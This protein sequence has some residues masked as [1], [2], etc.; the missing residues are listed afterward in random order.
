MPHRIRE[1]GRFA[2]NITRDSILHR[3]IEALSSHYDPSNP[4]YDPYSPEYNPKK[5]ECMTPLDK[6]A[7]YERMARRAVLI[8]EHLAQDI[9][10]LLLVYSKSNPQT[11]TPHALEIL[12]KLQE[13]NVP[14]YITELNIAKI[15]QAYSTNI[16]LVSF[17]RRDDRM[18]RTLDIL[19][20]GMI[21]PLKLEAFTKPK[22]KGEI[23]SGYFSSQ[24]ITT[25]DLEGVF[26]TTDIKVRRSV[27]H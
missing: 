17:H 10:N 1:Q 3:F 15:K 22:H 11:L 19:T 7:M 27:H 13:D 18:N 5:H 21:V 16:D 23:N 2:A 20:R 6:A 25:R 9:H 4:I 14:I 26:T 24:S 12:R 8:D